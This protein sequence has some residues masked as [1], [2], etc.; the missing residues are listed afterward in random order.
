MTFTWPEALFLLALVPAI[1][2]LR[3]DAETPAA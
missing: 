2:W 1:A 3:L